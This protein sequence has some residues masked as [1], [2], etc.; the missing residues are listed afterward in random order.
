MAHNS[1]HKQLV[2][3][4]KDRCR[5]CFTCVRECPVKAIKIVNGQA[6][7]LSER[8]IGCGNC[9]R[10]CRQE[11][12]VFL[13]Q[14]SEVLELLQSGTRTAACLAP[15]FPAE[16]TGIED[17]RVLV[18]MVK[19]LG[20]DLVTEVAFGADM[21]AVAYRKLFEN[22]DS[23]GVISSDCPAIVYYVEHFQPELV[24]QLAP[25]VSPMVAASRYLKKKYGDDLQTV[26]I[27]PC[28]AK[29]AESDDIDFALT[30][31]ELR[32]L[33]AEKGIN[34][35]N[36]KP[37]EFDP[38][39]AGKGAVF[40]ISHGLLQNMQ[41]ESDLT[42]GDVIVAEG[43]INFKDA[44]TEFAQGKLQTRH[45][46]L[47]CCEG[48]IMGPGM[49]KD[50]V[51]YQRRS[52]IS[53]YV[54]Q[55]M[56]NIDMG[57]WEKELIQASTIDLSNSFQPMDRRL[58]KPSSQKIGE[59]LFRMGKNDASDYLDCG[60]CGYDTCIEHA[61]AIVQGLAENEMCLPYSIETLHQSVEKLNL[62]NIELASAREALKQSEKLAHMGQLSAGIAHE[63]NNP[64]GVITMYSN[65]ILDETTDE[66]TRNDLQLIVEQADR[67][68]KIV[69][70]LLNFAR[71]NQVRLT[72]THLEKFATRSVQSIVVPENII[73][74]LKV[75]M[76]NPYLFLD[77]DQMMQVLTNLEK[78]A[79]EAMPAGGEL[80]IEL[81]EKK[82][83]VEIHIKD[84]GSGIS[85]ENMEKIFTP[86][87][88]T[89]EVGKGTGLGLP[90]CYG[91]IKMHKGKISVIS[92]CNPQKGP[93]GTTFIISLP[94]N[95][96]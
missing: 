53:K 51:K 74:N 42:K 85:E 22:N 39:F 71:K 29:K 7:V 95:P 58:E 14:T 12:K 89:K 38:P 60:A 88:T 32:E 13:K 92:N 73:V 30:F 24:S 47:L 16:F 67:C 31:S 9:V 26:F 80:T 18:S 34:Q 57:A 33:F 25:L 11:A 45:L 46:E 94:R 55:K 27:G 68:R 43:R 83:D 3:T 76:K 61:I 96:A 75:E 90:L 56:E 41:V 15:S 28:I 21:V 23:K 48:C 91:I 2:F 4:V 93:T 77:V 59:V 6:E 66:T 54:G 40:P 20:F 84:S 8:C 63:L 1:K 37:R 35:N 62:S 17:Y 5:V 10:V 65:L 19:S 69:G 87:F 49:S 70:G 86:F 72:E 64:L 79:V 52:C 50:G 81:I 82:D 44:I 36:V 78:N